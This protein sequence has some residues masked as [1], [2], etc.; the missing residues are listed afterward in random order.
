MKRVDKFL[1]AGDVKE[2]GRLYSLKFHKSISQKTKNKLG[3]NNELQR[4]VKQN[5]IDFMHIVIRCLVKE[6]PV[7]QL[8]W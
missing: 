1:G 4:K 5:H 7:Y 8:L 6:R 2:G 3:S